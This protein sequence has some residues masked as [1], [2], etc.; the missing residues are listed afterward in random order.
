MSERKINLEEIICDI[1]FN[2][3]LLF[4]VTHNGYGKTMYTEIA[5]KKAMLEFG[6]RLLKVAAENAECK[7]KNKIECDSYQLENGFVIGNNAIVIN[8]QSILDTIN[9]IECE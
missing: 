4:D 9:Q 6:K 7:L 5:M 1:D 8:K 3:E 2:D